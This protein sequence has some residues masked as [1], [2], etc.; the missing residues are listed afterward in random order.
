MRS[1]AF[2]RG[3]DRA[4][5]ASA[6]VSPADGEAGSSPTFSCHRCGSCCTG[7]LER[8]GERGFAEPAPGVYRLPSQ[9]GLRLFA[10]EARRFDEGDLEP[11]LVVADAREDRRVAVSYELRAD[12]CPNFDAEETRCTIYEDR[13]IVCRAFPLLLEADGGEL[14]VAASSVCGVRVP[15]DAL[16]TDEEPEAALARAYPEAAPAALAAA[17]ILAWSLRVVAFLEQAGE[18]EPQPGLEEADV[19]SFE[20]G[21]CLVELAE[22]AGLLEASEF[23]EKADAIVD[24]VDER[25]ASSAAAKPA[26]GAQ[27]QGHEQRR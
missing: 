9:G 10:W 13:P 7:L 26:P 19:R 11:S 21:G 12:T 4:S 25:L 5:Q 15:L 27:R 18:L 20:D 22:E 14:G 16:D 23:E 8:G 1:A 6:T 24:R 3:L 17:R 2:G